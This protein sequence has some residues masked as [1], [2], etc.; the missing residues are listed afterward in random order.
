MDSKSVCSLFAWEASWLSYSCGAVAAFGKLFPVVFVQIVP[1]ILLMVV[2][3][4][5]I[6]SCWESLLRF[7][8]VL[9]HLFSQI[10]VPIKSTV[11]MDTQLLISMVCTFLSWY[12]LIVISHVELFSFWYSA[13]MRCSITSAWERRCI[14][15][16][17]TSFWC[18]LIPNG[19]LIR[20]FFPFSFYLSVCLSVFNR[21]LFIVNKTSMT[22]I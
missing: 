14:F 1:G 21:R 8:I 15:V 18:W 19:I 12:L 4:E 6:L 17:S 2:G 16:S 7:F 3:M 20:F 11:K 13:S 9:Y 10:Q 5:F 22:I